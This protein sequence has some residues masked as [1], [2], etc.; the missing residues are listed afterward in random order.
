M[1]AEEAATLLLFQKVVLVGAE[2]PC[3]MAGATGAVAAM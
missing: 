2:V 3:F 1:A